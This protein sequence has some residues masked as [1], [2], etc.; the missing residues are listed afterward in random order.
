MTDTNRGKQAL[1]LFLSAIMVLSVVAIGG[2]TFAGSAAGETLSD[3]PDNINATITSNPAEFGVDANGVSGG[4]LSH[5]VTIEVDDDL[6]GTDPTSG[7]NDQITIDYSSTFTLADNPF[8]KTEVDAEVIDETDGMQ[9]D[10]D[11]EGGSNGG[12]SH[13]VRENNITITFDDS[14]PTLN[15]GDLIRIRLDAASAVDAGSEFA[16]PAE[17]E[18]TDVT[19]DVQD[20]GDS[21]SNQAEDISLDLG[22]DAPIEVD[23][24]DDFSGSANYSS[25]QQAVSNLA[26]DGESITI[27]SNV[28]ELESQPQSVT[29][30][31][32]SDITVDESGFTIESEGNLATVSTPTLSSGNAYLDLD[33]ASDN[34]TIDN[35]GFAVDDRLKVGSS[36]DNAVFEDGATGNLTITDSEFDGFGDA[37]IDVDVDEGTDSDDATSNIS[38]NIFTSATEAINIDASGTIDAGDV[39]IVQD[40]DVQSFSGTSALEIAGLSSGVSLTFDAN[41]VDAGGSGGTNAITLSSASENVSITNGTIANVPTGVNIDASGGDF[42]E[43]DNVTF[44]S[45]S[46]TGTGSGAVAVTSS[47]QGADTIRVTQIT[48]TNSESGDAVTFNAND[49]SLEVTDGQLGSDG[50]TAVST[51]V[52]VGGNDDVTVDGTEFNLSANS[53][54][55]IDATGSGYS[56][57][58]DVANITVHAADGASSTT[59]IEVDDASFTGTLNID[60]ADSQ[61]ST[62]EDVGTGIDIADVDHSSATL[63]NIANTTIQQVGSAGVSLTEADGG[64]SLTFEN[65]TV[66]TDGANGIVV[67]DGDGDHADVTLTSG[68]EVTVAGNANGI[69]IDNAGSITVED[70]TVN[71]A[72]NQDSVGI[73]INDD[74][75]GSQ[76]VTIQRNTIQASGSQSSGVGVEVNTGGT[77]TFDY[78]NILGFT[79]DG[80]GLDGSGITNVD[81]T[82]NWWGDDFG[83]RNASGSNVDV[84]S[85]NAD[86]YDPFLTANTSTQVAETSGVDSLDQLTDD[87]ITQF[88]HSLVVEN[89]DTVAYPGTSEN[90]I[91]EAHIEFTGMILGWNASDQSWEQVTSERPEGLDAYKIIYENPGD[92][93]TVFLVEYASETSSQVNKGSYDYKKGY[94]LVASAKY[95]TSLSE[96]DPTNGVDSVNTFNFEATGE[97]SVGSAGGGDY[98]KYGGTSFANTEAAAFSG[99]TTVSPLQ[100][101]WVYAYGSSVTESTAA[102]ID[103]SVTL[104]EIEDDGQ[105]KT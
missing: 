84:S 56:S 46:G 17:G 55:A 10:G 59:G 60:N 35:V 28:S 93:Q 87:D 34:V 6:D 81:A 41:D 40:N 13:S 80:Y 98:Q 33:D 7:N 45:I 23:S 101:Y 15:E 85:S 58:L 92:S 27:R 38:N 89:G 83:P 99:S 43:V 32:V 63:N 36:V 19:V 24:D 54:E 53:G 75:G 22:T 69:Q 102:P 86:V 14:A 57:T 47:A 20:G 29:G 31:G 51:G 5:V 26:S 94:N 73:Y 91:D 103:P 64:Y 62:I 72:D 76:D 39:V 3:T 77:S 97:V 90:T 105:L 67:D 70:S 11:I 25:L 44:D 96:T 100:G 88:G 9:E 68:S 37:A 18:N 78:N 16:H 82:A 50:G 95:S 48:V 8:T 42:A 61:A 104:S 30:G 79:D 65:I 21:S 1:S 66:D 52:L 49:A 12:V 74:V 71:V 4:S 2:A